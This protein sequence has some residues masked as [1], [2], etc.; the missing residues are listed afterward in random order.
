MDGQDDRIRSVEYGIKL[1]HSDSGSQ[2]TDPNLSPREETLPRPPDDLDYHVE[3]TDSRLR[4]LICSLCVL[5]VNTESAEEPCCHEQ[6]YEKR[7][8]LNVNALVNAWDRWSCCCNMA[9]S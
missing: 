6:E 9:A 8:F 4:A 2:F 7:L 3:V 1:T 5:F